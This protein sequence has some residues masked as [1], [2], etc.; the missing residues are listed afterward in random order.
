M[1]GVVWLILIFA[2]AVV[3][4][5]VLG[6]NDGLVTLAFGHWRAELSLNLFVVLVLGLCLA[7]MAIVRALDALLSLPRRAGEWRALQRERAAQSALAEAQ[8]EYF[9]AR[10]SRAN[11][12]AQ[13]ALT[14]Q[15]D[16]PGLAS[17]VQ[18]RLLAQLLAAGSLHRLQDTARRDE[19]LR[20]IGNTTRAGAGRAAAEGASLLM[21]EWALDDRDADKALGMLAAL[22]P[23]VGRRTQALRLRLRAARMAKRPMEALDTARLLAKHGAF[24]PDAAKGLLRTL[25]IEVLDTAHDADQLRREWQDLEAADRRDPTVAARAARRAA[26]FGASDDARAWLVPFWDRMTDLSASDREAVAIALCD[27]VQ[28]VGIDWLPRAEAAVS[29]L[30]AEPAV[31]AA[32][33]LVF[34]ERQLWGKALRLLELAAASRTLDAATRRRCWRT[35]A[36]LAREDGDDARAAA[37]DREAAVID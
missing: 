13:R 5:T 36:A 30:P 19:M 29:A 10:Y 1:R 25:A 11:K 17:D 18:S 9:A 16:T 24:S 8:S 31:S 34:A 4:A 14:I 33:G 3:A 2:A 37:C 27:A 22:P 15:D 20:R 28:G 12:A 32:A 6:R 35:L 21:A 7:F 26:A 23:G